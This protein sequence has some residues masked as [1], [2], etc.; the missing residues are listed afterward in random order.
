[1]KCKIAILYGSG[2]FYA[3]KK[4]MKLERG[5]YVLLQVGAVPFHIP[6]LPQVLISS[7]DMVSSC[8]L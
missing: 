5:K 6:S 3:H 1:M 4:R 7:P 2:V 8:P